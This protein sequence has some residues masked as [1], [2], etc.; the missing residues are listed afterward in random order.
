MRAYFTQKTTASARMMLREGGAEHRGDGEREDE[1]GDGEE[2]VHEPH[3]DLVHLA[4][5]EAGEAA[6]DDA[7]GHG[8]AD[9]DQRQLERGAGAPDDAVEH[10]AAVVPWCRAGGPGVPGGSRG[11]AQSRGIW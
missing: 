3:Q 1:L 11:R 4:A 2:D 9:H 6:D 8:D 7:D 10:V 5:D